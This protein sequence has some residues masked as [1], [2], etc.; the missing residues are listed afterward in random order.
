MFL[1]TS[2]YSAQGGSGLETIWD[3]QGGGTRD[4]FG[5]AV[6]NAGDVNGDG[7]EDII[8]GA[9]YSNGGTS[10]Y[11]SYGTA[12]VYSG[13][14]GALMYQ[15]DAAVVGT[16]YAKVVSGAGDVNG[17]G[18]DDIIIGAYDASPNGNSHAGSAF[19]HSGA[20][21]ALLYRLDGDPSLVSGY[22]FGQSVSDLGDV[23]GDGF[24]DLLIGAPVTYPNGL[25]RAGSA[26]VFSGINGTLLYQIDGLVNEGRLGIS[27]SGIG[28]VDGDGRGDFVLGSEGK[29]AFIHSGATGALLYQLQDP[30]LVN[31]SYAVSGAGDVNNDGIPDLIIGASWADTSYAPTAGMVRVYSGDTGAL[32]YQFEGQSN[33]DEFGYSVSG[34]GDVNGDGFDDVVIGAPYTMPNGVYFVGSFY[35]YSGINGSLLYQVNG[36]G[37]HDYFGFAVSAAGDTNNDGF[38]DIV[39]GAWGTYVNGNQSVG[40]A[41]VYSFA[42]LEPYLAIS[43]T[44]ISSSAGGQVDFNM[45]FPVSQ[46]GSRYMLLASF[47]TADPWTKNGVECPLSPY[48]LMQEM[49]FNPPS[50]FQQPRGVLDANGNGQCV[51][52][53]PPGFLAANAGRQMWFAAV[54][55]DSNQDLTGS[56]V[57]VSLDILP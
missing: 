36:D 52:L 1:S 11:N 30:L 38:D 7:F 53:V 51:A 28:D 15:F 35:V 18:F 22:N 31:F 26:F 56:S 3:W 29:T 40:A 21:G 9:P 6:S 39:S 24:D 43:T 49:I 10:G 13:A 8:V 20:N 57:A 41:A 48:S 42:N 2:S 44:Q 45:D 16:Q 47:D 14:T 34:A 55:Y 33:R 19:V 27:A 54:T 25:T 12:Y 23:N 37:H 46:A 32:L 50:F 5:Q 4:Y 17:D